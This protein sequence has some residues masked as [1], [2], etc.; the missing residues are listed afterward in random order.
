MPEFATYLTQDDK[1]LTS[2]SAQHS[3]TDAYIALYK[4]DYVHLYR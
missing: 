3:N 1:L 4:N 2:N